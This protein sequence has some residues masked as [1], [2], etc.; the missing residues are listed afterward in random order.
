MDPHIHSSIIHSSQDTEAAQGCTSGSVDTYAHPHTHI[1]T[2][3]H[4]NAYMHTYNRTPSRHMKEG[5]C[6]IFDSVYQAGGN[7]PYE[8][9]QT[10]RDKQGERSLARVS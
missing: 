8:V 9:S 4:A 2:D 1:H 5:S 10:E 3:R 7:V 6:V